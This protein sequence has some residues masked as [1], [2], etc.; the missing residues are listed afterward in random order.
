MGTKKTNSNIPLKPFYGTG[1]K[2]GEYP[3]TNGV[4]PD[5]YRER[6]W[7]T[8]QYAGFTSA[9]ESNKRYR[10]LI[11]QGVMGLSVAFDLPTQTGYDSDHAL[12]VGEIGKVGVPICSVADMEI[13]FNDIRLD[14]VSVSMTINSTAAI[15]LAFL[16]V[17]AERQGINRDKLNG[18]VQN[19]ILKEY[20]ARG[21]YIYPPKSSMRIITDI[22]EFCSNE[23]PKWNTISISGYHIR[24]AGSTAVEELAFTLANGIAYVQAAIDKGLDVNSFGKRVSFFFNCHNHFFEEIAKFRAARRI[25]ATVMKK[26][27]SATEPKAMMCRFHTQTAGSTLQAQQI[28]N[29]VVRTTLQATAAI[30]GGTQSLHTNAR[31][32]ALALPSEKSAQLALR[33]QQIIAHESGIP[34]VADPLAGSEY[35]EALTDELENSAME[36]INKIDEIGGAVI[37]IEQEYQQNEIASSAFDYQKAID[38]G[39]NIMVGVNKYTTGLEEDIETQGIDEQA[40]SQQLEQLKK[41]K[42]NRNDDVVQTSL[43]ALKESASSEDNLMPPIVHAVKARATLGEISD[44]LRS[45]FGEH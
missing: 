2:P 26:R 45:V 14:K 12:A 33:T 21:T 41:F 29:N 22:F 15:L 11:D 7:T 23:M 24:E 32:E 19:D 43:S 31:D 40:V 34:D 18:T 17:A 39:E 3:F 35:V 16:I 25:W 38:K 42:Q 36:L 37:A 10:Y 20:I 28:D 4:Y 1:S 13:L 27:F 9:E 6:L 30:L 44:I 8:R 5:M